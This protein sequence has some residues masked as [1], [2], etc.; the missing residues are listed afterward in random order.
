VH[1]E[2]DCPPDS[3]LIS[4]IYVSGCPDLGDTCVITSADF[5]SLVGW[6]LGNPEDF[7]VTE[8]DRI[9]R[10]MEIFR[11][12]TLYKSKHTGSM[13]E[14]YS[15]IIAYRN[16]R[17]LNITNDFKVF[18]WD[19][20]EIMM[21]RM[22]NSYGIVGEEMES[23]DKDPFEVELESAKALFRDIGQR[24]HISEGEEQTDF[25]QCEN[26]N[27]MDQVILGQALGEPSLDETI[28]GGHGNVGEVDSNS[29]F[30]AG[31]LLN[32][33]S[34]HLSMSMGQP[35]YSQSLEPSPV[36]QVAAGLDGGFQDWAPINNETSAFANPSV[37]G[38]HGNIGEVDSHS[39][40][41]AGDL[42]N[43]GS[44]HM[45]MSMGQ[46]WY[47]QPLEP[48]Q[49]SQVAGGLD[50]VFQDL[51]PINNT[52]AFANSSVNQETSINQNL[53]LFTNQEFGGAE[54][55]EAQLN[56]FGAQQ[57]LTPLNILN[58]M[59]LERTDAGVTTQQAQPGHPHQLEHKDG[60]E[61]LTPET[62]TLWDIDDFL[63]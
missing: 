15:Q 43:A 2:Q 47:S 19:N 33:G 49:V 58:R 44:L 62:P 54:T 28:F 37:F 38:G 12:V 34:L 20:L 36:S 50:G 57:Q 56:H 30:L 7:D 6:M 51:A 11:P 26:L 17:P 42:L 39:A 27:S 52:S 14:L 48:S 1:T 24:D 60:T 16:P 46:P 63:K 32:A 55:N 8:R 21:R 40:F 53:Y 23:S 22:A 3:K 18:R 35:W 41:L 25:T 5:L 10:N 45:S 61:D 9:R 31:D 59:A 29:G 13:W 4:C